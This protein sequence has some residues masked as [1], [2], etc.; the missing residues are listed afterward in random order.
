M[1]RRGVS[2]KDKREGGVSSIRRT[3]LLA[4]EAERARRRDK[5]IQL[6]GSIS[7][8]FSEGDDSNDYRRRRRQEGRT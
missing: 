6:L 5:N 8:E 1:K 2:G 4:G 3:S 7:E